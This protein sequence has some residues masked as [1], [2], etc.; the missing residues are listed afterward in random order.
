MR[1]KPIRGMATIAAL[2]LTL[3]VAACSSSKKSA[4]STS[5]TAASSG[6]ATTASS[7]G[8]SS[9]SNQ[10]NV[11]QWLQRPTSINISD[12][13]TGSIP[14][15]KTIDWLQ[16]SVPACVALTAPLQEAVSTVGWTLRVVDAGVTPESIKAAW[17][18]AVQ[19]KPDAVIAS[20]FSRSIFEPELA[21]LKSLN[22]PVIDMTTADPPGNGLTAVFDY[23][24]DYLASGQRL[25]DY[26]ISQVGTNVNAV[27]VTSSAF[28]NLGFVAQGFQQ[29]LQSKC[30]SCKVD[31]FQVPATS[32]GADL[33]T[34]I[35]SYFTAHPAV[36]LAYIGYDDMVLGVP[37]AM[38]SAG[39]SG[40]VK[41]VT[42]DNEPATQAYMKNGQGLVASDGFPGP[43][44]MWR[45]VDFLIRTFNNESTAPDTAHNLPVWL[46]TGANVPS[47]TSSF[48]LV[49][50]YQ[51]Q[52]KA[53]WGM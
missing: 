39:I 41:L 36:N 53:L 37:A 19:D 29:E 25:A 17:D 15:G 34:R 38:S 31:S 26:A 47:T 8:T 2:G 43:E 20:G 4:S 9:G 21:Q 50:D 16:C 49:A 33:P 12:K 22:I 27:M 51:A 48:P 42:I 30:P 6:S 14:K 28:A 52:Y 45:E 10:A 32:I 5:T 11:Q 24:P 13:V 3:S 23:G 44:I 35:A 1:R 18:K 40:K 46:L 7:S